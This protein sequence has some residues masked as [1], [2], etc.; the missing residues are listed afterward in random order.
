MMKKYTRK[1]ISD[2]LKIG[3][4]TL[5]YYEKLGIIPEPKRS[6]TSY[7]LYN[8]DDILRLKFIKRLKELGFSLK[9][10]YEILQ[11]LKDN[12]NEN[13]GILKNKCLEKISQIESK[14]LTM[15]TLKE[16][17]KISMNNP[18]LGECEF[19]NLFYKNS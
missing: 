9:E 6:E 13:K 10:I 15:N 16:T 17:L 4:E 19:L 14:I 11:L 12:K 18:K 5:R 8:N 2:I 3:I 1:E 7:R